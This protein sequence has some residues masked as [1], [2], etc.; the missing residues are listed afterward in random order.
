MYLLKFSL[1]NNLCYVYFFIF[2]PGIFPMSWIKQ[3]S[4]NIGQLGSTG[5][6]IQL[7]VSWWKGLI[8]VKLCLLVLYCYHCCGFCTF[9]ADSRLL[10]SLWPRL[11]AQNVFVIKEI[12]DNFFFWHKG[13]DLGSIWTG[14]KNFVKVLVFSK[15]FAKIRKNTCVRIVID[16][17]DTVQRGCWLHRHHVSVVNSYMD[18]V[19]A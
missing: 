9:L 17:P 4:Q 5:N 2:I 10:K 14:K 1:R 18:A 3:S 8:N 19:L 16:Y 7:E 6:W 13:F 15:I 11:S 12:F